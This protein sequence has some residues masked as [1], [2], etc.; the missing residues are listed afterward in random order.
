MVVDT[1]EDAARALPRDGLAPRLRD[2]YRKCKQACRGRAALAR[3]GVGRHAR[4]AGAGTRP[5]GAFLGRAGARF[6]TS[7]GIFHAA[8]AAAMA[9]GRDVASR[10]LH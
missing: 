2:L 1:S 10:P 9:C 7:V 4:L 8:T 6:G 3:G 5:R